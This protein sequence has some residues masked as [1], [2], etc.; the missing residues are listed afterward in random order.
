MRCLLIFPQIIVL[1]AELFISCSSVVCAFL[2]AFYEYCMRG[3]RQEGSQVRG[4][5][6]K[7]DN[8]AELQ[9]QGRQEGKQ[10]Q[11]IKRSERLE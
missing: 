1:Y 3:G 5:E 2:M 9:E 6:R 7:Y 8:G 4:G 10:R 11:K